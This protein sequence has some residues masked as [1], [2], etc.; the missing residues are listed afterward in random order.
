LALNVRTG[1]IRDLPAELRVGDVYFHN[2]FIHAAA[3]SAPPGSRKCVGAAIVTLDP[4][5]PPHPRTVFWRKSWSRARDFETPHPDDFTLI[6]EDVIY[7]LPPP[8]FLFPHAW[9]AP[10]RMQAGA[11]SKQRRA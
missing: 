9:Q 8:R 6:P 2:M 11:P 4:A 7:I 10:P 5:L 1:A 3:L